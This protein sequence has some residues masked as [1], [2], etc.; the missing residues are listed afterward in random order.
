[1]QNLGSDQGQSESYTQQ[2]NKCYNDWFED[3]IDNRT[4][5]FICKNKKFLSQTID[6]LT[7]INS[8]SYEFIPKIRVLV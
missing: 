6:P 7:T 4:K 8:F 3:K 2:P 1:M 5:K